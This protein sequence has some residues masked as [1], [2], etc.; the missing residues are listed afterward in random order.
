MAAHN[1]LREHTHWCGFKG[2]IIFNDE[3]FIKILNFYLFECP[4]PHS[5]VRAKTFRDYKWI[6]ATEFADLQRKLS[7]ASSD[8]IW[9]HRIAVK[10]LYD[11]LVKTKQLDKVSLSKE[12]VIYTDGETSMATLFKSI[13]NAFAH[14][15]FAI[16]TVK[17]EHYYCLENRKP[18]EINPP[19]I[20]ARI[21]LK[22]TTMLEWI[23]IVKAGYKRK[24]S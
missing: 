16:R 21:V 4:A 20:R 7:N 5:S 18:D 12:T 14:G 3:N 8:K 13:R 2:K 9:I 10:D 17:G 15:S 24:K 1:E 11:I 6:T 22:E 23:K 19:E